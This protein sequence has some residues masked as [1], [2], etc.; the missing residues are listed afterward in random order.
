MTTER[1]LPALVSPRL[2]P[3]YDT[4]A[5]LGGAVPM[6]WRL[7][8]QACIGP[9]DRVLEIGCGTG[10]VVLRAKEAV[11]TASVTGIDP[12]SD[13][14]AIAR[15]KA[16]AAGID[17]RFEVGVAEELPVGDGALDRVL[18][19][20]MLHHVAADTRVAALREAR[21]VLAPGGSLHLVDLDDDPG[22]GGRMR[23][24]NAL[25]SLLHRLDP[26][27]RRHGH[28]GHGHGQGHGHGHGQAQRPVRELLAEAGFAEP[29][30]VG[31]GTTL[32]GGVGY[33]RA[34][35]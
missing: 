19:S 16:A 26:A 13:A 27:A 9:G 17:V 12:D 11:P 20:L 10:N 33:Y 30:L 7:L 5:R 15:R 28:G 25:L 21:R 23:P 2:L 4:V 35:A 6:Y 14:L 22:V 3:G 34:Q 29:T 8:T 31:H 1:Y 18:S 24:V 32:M